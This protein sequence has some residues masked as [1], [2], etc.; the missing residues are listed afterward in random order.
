MLNDHHR[1]TEADVRRL[2]AGTMSAREAEALRHALRRDEDAQRMYDQLVAAERAL[3]GNRDEGGLGLAARARVGDRLFESLRPAPRW[4]V[5]TLSWSIGLTAA[6]A[7]VTAVMLVPSVETGR[8]SDD[9]R[10]RSGHSGPVVSSDRVLQVLQIAPGDDGQLSVRPATVIRPSDALRFAAFVRAES[11][12]VS[13]LAVLADGRRQ[14]LLER[15]AIEPRPSAQRLDVAFSV[16]EEWRGQVRFVGVFEG[17]QDV[18]LKTVDL[19]A[20]DAEGWSVRV[21]RV[22]AGGPD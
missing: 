15:A 1:P 6:T 14:I 22:L 4:S 12:R 7:A 18:D 19:G 11:W 10:A 5:G 17:A 13:V 20:R 8:E 2:L 9:Y 16:P 21:V 3:E